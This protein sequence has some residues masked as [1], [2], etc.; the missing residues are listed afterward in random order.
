MIGLGV[1]YCWGCM[2][3]LGCWYWVSPLVSPWLLQALF[4]AVVSLGVSKWLQALDMSERLQAF[5]QAL[6][7]VVALKVYFFL[8]WGVGMWKTPL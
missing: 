5:L 2:K 1:L 3:A 6:S 8:P 7:F 4:V